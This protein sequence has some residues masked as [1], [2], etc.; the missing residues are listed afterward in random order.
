MMRKLF[1]MMLI[2]AGKIFYPRLRADIPQTMYYQ[3]LLMDYFGNNVPDGSY[4]LVFN[5]Y[6]RPEGGVAL[7]T[8]TQNV[9]VEDGVFKV[10]LGVITPLNMSFEDTRWL[11][12]G[13]GS[14]SELQPR[15]SLTAAAHSL[16]AR[17]IADCIAM[18]SKIIS[19]AANC[20]K[21]AVSSVCGLHLIDAPLPRQN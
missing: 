19:G 21:L 13:L 8:E 12:I 9:T 1:F 17:S 3:G 2:T 11:G 16:N 15:V 14:D 18:T 6:N 10:I 4:E 7:W 5:F 20:V